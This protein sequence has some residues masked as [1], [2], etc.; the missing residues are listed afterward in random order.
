MLFVSKISAGWV[1]G[2]AALLVV[3]LI[4]LASAAAPSSA[5]TTFYCNQIYTPPHTDCVEHLNIEK[6]FANHNQGYAY[7]GDGIPVCEHVTIQYQAQK[8]SNRCGSSPVD[9]Q[10][11]LQYWGGDTTVFSMFTGN[12]D[13]FYVYMDGKGYTGTVCA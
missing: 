8:I 10:C 3:S 4:C 11:D 6:R 1:S 13:A 12:N 5:D 9:S 7:H 2:L